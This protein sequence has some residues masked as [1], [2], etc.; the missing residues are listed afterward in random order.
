MILISNDYSFKIFC[1]PWSI[2]FT[3]LKVAWQPNCKI[4]LKKSWKRLW[5][6]MDIHSFES[7]VSLTIETTY[8]YDNFIL[9]IFVLTISPLSPVSPLSPISPFSPV[10]PW[11]PLGPGGPTGPVLPFSPGIIVATV[12]CQ[13]IRVLILFVGISLHYCFQSQQISSMGQ[14]LEYLCHNYVLVK[15]IPIN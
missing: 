9:T 14:L 6:C 13:S 3:S 8:Y 4:C 1:F 10:V 11:S 7:L 15:I 12:P 2:Y 5:C